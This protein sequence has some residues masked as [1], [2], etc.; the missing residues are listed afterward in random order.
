M[1]VACQ[2]SLLCIWICLKYS[3]VL[4][5]KNYMQFFLVMFMGWVMFPHPQATSTDHGGPRTSDLYGMVPLWNASNGMPLR[6]CKEDF[7]EESD[8]TSSFFW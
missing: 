7:N 2:K 8:L 3:V 1:L 4:L 5:F 6:E